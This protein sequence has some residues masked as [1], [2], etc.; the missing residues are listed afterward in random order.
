MEAQLRIEFHDEVEIL[1]PL[2]VTHKV[3]R[4]AK[5]KRKRGR[6][7]LGRVEKEKLLEAGKDH[8]F[9]GKTAGEKGPKSPLIGSLFAGAN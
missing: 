6:K 9:S 2:K 3:A 7:A 4:L 1:F 8:R 5:A